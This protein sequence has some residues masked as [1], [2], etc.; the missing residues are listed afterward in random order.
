[1]LQD[2]AQNIQT[3]NKLISLSSVGQCCDGECMTP[4]H[5]PHWALARIY[6]MRQ[7]IAADLKQIFIMWIRLGELCTDV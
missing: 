2:N 6:I 1:M 7:L 4:P 3:Q 5:P